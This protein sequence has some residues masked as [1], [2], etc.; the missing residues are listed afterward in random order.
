MNRAMGG[1]GFAVRDPLNLNNLNPAA[2][3]SIQ[4]ATQLT[5][6]GLF[7]ESDRYRNEDQGASST[8]GNITSMNLWVRFNK[9][10][11][12]AAGINPFST[13]HYNITYSQRA[14]SSQ[15]LQYI[16]SGGVSQYYFGNAFQLTKNLSLG[17]TASFLHGS[18]DRREIVTS[19]FAFGTEVNNT[20]A[21][22]QGKLD[23]G[24]QYSIP[25]GTDQSLTIGAVY[26]NRLRLNTSHQMAIYQSTDT[27]AADKTNIDDYVLPQKLGSGIAFQS[28]QSIFTFDLSFQQWSKAR[29]EDDLKLRDTRKLAFGYQYRGDGSESFWNG[30][31]LR[32]GGYVQENPMILQNTTFRDWGVTV[33]I[34]I[35]VSNRRNSLNL[36]Y[37]FNR[38]GTLEKNLITQQSHIF[39]LD[40]TFRDLW[41]I[42]R[43]FD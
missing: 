14:G 15:G 26:D 18:I 2:Y 5:E 35:P 10:W 1:S 6:L 17:V 30:V 3:T 11:A 29:L 37:S 41:G 19:G 16:G 34:G 43:K 36:S 32:T 8:T 33:G 21:V 40:I 39:A 31:V 42:R 23:F 9:R 13:V 27:I 28:N 12:G 24:L 25:M 38:S 20:T 7:V 4:Q 22:R